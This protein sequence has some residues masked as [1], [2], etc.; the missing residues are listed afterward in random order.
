MLIESRFLGVFMIAALVRLMVLVACFSLSSLQAEENVY[1]TLVEQALEKLQSVTPSEQ[2][3]GILTRMGNAGGIVL[4]ATLAAVVY[5]IINDNVTARMCIEYFNSPAHSGHY[6]GMKRMGFDNPGDVTSPTQIALIWG[7]VATWWVGLI[8]GTGVAACATVGSSFPIVTAQELIKPL[9]KLLGVM[10]VG[11]SAAGLLGYI[12]ASLGWFED[13]WVRQ[14]LGAAKHN[15]FM[16]VGFAHD[17]GYLFGGL[18]GL[19][20]MAHV[21]RTR[22]L[23]LDDMRKAA[24]VN[25]LTVFLEKIK[26][27]PAQVA[28]LVA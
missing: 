4:M 1:Q 28:S 24:V 22:I 14:M 23:K 12:G 9:L 13:S 21:I 19:V 6:A 7:V 26:A 10:F 15:V 17:A 18:G 16:A 2:G 27:D 8:L 11:A 5:G 25:L 3:V 20:L